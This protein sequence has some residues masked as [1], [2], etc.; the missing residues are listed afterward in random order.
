MDTT[1][2]R[3]L[4]LAF[5]LIACGRAPAEPRPAASPAA[6]QNPGDVVAQVEGEPITRSEV[7]AKAEAA[8]SQVREEEYQARRAAL[9]ELVIERLLD[10]E[11]KARGLSRE[12]LLQKEV[13]ERVPK[14]TAQ[15]IDALYEQNKMRMGGRSRQE[16]AP[17]I[18]R[19]IRQQGLDARRQVFVAELRGRSKVVVKLAQPR[20][21]VPLPA[22]TP[23]S[24]PADAPITMVEFS[25]YLC[26]YCQRAQETVDAVLARNAGKVKFVHQDYLL[27]RPRSL[28]VARAAHCAGDQGKFWE[29]R[30]ALMGSRTGWEDPQLIAHAQQLGIDQ[31]GFAKCLASDRH[32]EAVNDSSERGRQLGVDST[33]TFF[34]NGRRLKGAVPAEHFQ[35]IIDDE[36]SAAGR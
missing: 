24:G 10:R 30:K 14:P 6:P 20:T 27:G 22:G 2:R 9:E 36:L 18:E 3:W 28:E 31:A 5:C 12:K 23:A 32:D 21:E 29:Y 15:E 1:S 7:D 17:Q 8:L 16:M 13:D 35:Q 19:A 34:I 4:G 25:D 26:P 11:A 33:P